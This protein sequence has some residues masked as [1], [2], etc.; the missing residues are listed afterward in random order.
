MYVCVFGGRRTKEGRIKEGGKEG[1]KGGEEGGGRRGEGKFI[2]I[3][4]F[5]MT[6]P[7]SNP[8]TTHFKL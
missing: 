1:G 8:H 5:V 7:S 4:Y 2:T 6:H 3:I